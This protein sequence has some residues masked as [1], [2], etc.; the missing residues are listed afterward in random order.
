MG[1][2]R[3]AHPGKLI[4]TRLNVFDG[5]PYVKGPDGRGVPARSPLPLISCWGTSADDPFEPDLTE[6]I[7]LV[8]DADP[9]WAWGWSTSRWAIPYASPHLIRPFEYPP[10]DGYETPGASAPRRRPAFP[11]DRPRSSGPFPTWPSSGRAIAGSRRSPS[12]RAPRT[13]ATGGP[14]SSGSAAARWRSP[15]SAGG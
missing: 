10:P 1:R 13:S 5:I 2:I 3:D 4:A 9:G 14:R 11:A 6:P 12:R 8:G 7:A 15:N